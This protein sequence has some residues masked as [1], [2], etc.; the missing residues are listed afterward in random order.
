MLFNFRIREIRPAFVLPGKMGYGAGIQ[1]QEE[2]PALDLPK[3]M[4]HREGRQ[5]TQGP[6]LRCDDG[7]LPKV[8]S[9]R[10]Y[11]LSEKGH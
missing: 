3:A 11:F 9:G 6:R 2:V 1:T 10:L 5:R 7:G 8:S 4:G